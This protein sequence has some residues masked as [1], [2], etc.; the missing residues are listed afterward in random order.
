MKSKISIALVVVL[1]LGV[2]AVFADSHERTVLIWK[3]KLKEG[4]TTEDV[5][6]ANA[7]WVKNVNANAEDGEI[8]SFVLT[9]V[10]GNTNTFLYVDS[11]PTGAA[12]LASRE[13]T[14]TE[15]GQR[16]MKS[17]TQSLS[18]ARILF[19]KR[20]RPKRPSRAGSAG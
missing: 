15:E 17:S 10:V 14:Q 11:F 7:K 18:A 13:A 6:A 1:A 20:S 4:K 16:S 19:T 12:W 2:G 5:Q 3:C 8:R 9:T